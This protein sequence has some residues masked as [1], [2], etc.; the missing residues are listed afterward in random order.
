MSLHEGELPIDES[1]VVSLLREQ[2]PEWAAMPLAPVL[3]WSRGLA[4]P[5][6]MVLLPGVGH[7][8]HGSLAAL[9]RAVTET[10]GPELAAGSQV[11]AT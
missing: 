11:D 5:P 4:S 3:E 6:K 10:F 7:F 1:V 2:C 8:F 9:T